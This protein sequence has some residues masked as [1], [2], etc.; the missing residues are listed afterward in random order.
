MNTMNHRRHHA[1]VNGFTLIELLV[2]ISII[3]LLISILLPALGKA[4]KTANALKCA[5]LLRSMGLAN[6]MYSSDF[7]DW[8]APNWWR[9]SSTASKRYFFLTNSGIH[10]RLSLTPTDYGARWS[11]SFACPEASALNNSTWTNSDGILIRSVYG[12]NYHVGSFRGSDSN[13]STGTISGLK[14]SELLE[15]SKKPNL[16]DGLD[17]QI[18]YTYISSYIADTPQQNNT[19]AFRHLGTTHNA[20]FFDQHVSRISQEDSLADPDMWYFN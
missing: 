6:V 4:R 5:N 10:D 16:S 17:Q 1:P 7:K 11:H 3:A 20:V 15:P 13:W 2:V 19:P 12:H 14:F 8:A 9:E 18:G